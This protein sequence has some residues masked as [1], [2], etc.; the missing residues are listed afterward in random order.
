[1]AGVDLQ[2]QGG[3]LSRASLQPLQLA[4]RPLGVG[5]AHRLAIGAGV[6]LHHL[7][8]GLGGRGDLVGIGVDE[9]RDADARL[10]QHPH[11]RRHPVVAG[12]DIQPALGGQ[13]LA[14]LGH[15][16]GGVRPVVERDGQHLLG[17]RHLQVQRLAA[18]EAQGRQ[19]VDISVGDVAAILAQVGGDAVGA[20]RDGH[21][22]RA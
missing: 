4:H 3:G 7:G 21:F 5:L 14:P 10:A 18:P 19:L 8:A 9:Q 16:A 20:G 17:D 12:H 2:A 11:R 1:M 6:Q 13:L 15:Q 22:S